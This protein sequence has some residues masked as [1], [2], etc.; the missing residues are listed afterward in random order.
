MQV[1]LTKTSYEANWKGRYLILGIMNYNPKMY[2]EPFEIIDDHKSKL[3]TLKGQTIEELWVP[4][5]EVKDEW[6]NDLPV[7]IKFKT[8]QL[9]LCAYK[10]NQY[11]VTFDQIDLSQDID[12]YG[13]KLSW[14]KNKLVDLNEFLNNKINTVEIIQWMEQ[15]IGVGFDTNKGYFAVCNG[16]DQNELV[17]RKDVGHGYNYTQV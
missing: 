15:L 9:E 7:I 17:T 16:L 14:K 1:S 3:E 2:E 13:S 4:W 12:N 8:C 6:F 5:D 11:A 10:T